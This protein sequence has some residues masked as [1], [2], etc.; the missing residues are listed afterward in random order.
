MSFFMTLDMCDH[1]APGLPRG[2]FT[3]QIAR[4]T[5]KTV[6]VL[7]QFTSRYFDLTQPHYLV[8]LSLRERPIYTLDVSEAYQFKSERDA[9]AILTFD[10]KHE[11]WAAR[12][13]TLPNSQLH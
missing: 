3:I 8:K 11:G 13:V 5:M 1:V 12:Q 9:N 7:Q 2:F 6:W 4:A 10:L